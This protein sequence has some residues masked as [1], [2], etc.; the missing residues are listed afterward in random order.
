MKI[1][2]KGLPFALAFLAVVLAGPVT[3]RA[4]DHIDGLGGLAVQRWATAASTAPIPL[5]GGEGVERLADGLRE[6]YALDST[7]RIAHHGAAV[8]PPGGEGYVAH[9]FAIPEGQESAVV[10]DFGGRRAKLEFSRHRRLVQGEHLSSTVRKFRK[11]ANPK[12]WFDRVSTF[13]KAKSLDAFLELMPFSMRSRNL[14]ST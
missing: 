10:F 9:P 7:S 11:G 12:Y 14:N 3:S 5:Y 1:R 2:K 13:E 8:V 6:T 4:S